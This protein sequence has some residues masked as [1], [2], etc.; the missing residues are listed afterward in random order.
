MID[1]RFYLITDRTLCAP[2]SL[3]SIV[4]DAVVS[5]ARAVQLREKDFSDNDTVACA[6]RLMDTMRPYN[7]RLLVNVASIEDTTAQLIAGSPGVDGFHVPDDPELLKHVRSL[8]PKLLIGASAHSADGV[9]AAVDLGADFVVFGTIFGTPGKHG[10]AHGLEGLTAACAATTAP[11]FAVG[12][13]TAENAMSCRDAG[14][15]GVAVVRAVMEATS[16]RRAVREF[17]DAMGGL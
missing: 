6:T 3:A 1:F 15:H 5:G 2:R 14:A 8:F 10:K 17:A 4:H 9:R 12:G 7:A 11:V 13:I 16:A